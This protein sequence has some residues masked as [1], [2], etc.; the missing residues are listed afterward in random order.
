MSEASARDSA[1][2]EV[3]SRGATS[4]ASTRDADSVRYIVLRKLASGMR[5]ALMG[6]L[7]T[8]EFFAEFAARLLDQSDQSK[9]RECIEKIAPATQAAVKTCHS[10]IEWLRPDETSTLS[11]GDA[12]KQCLKLA[13]DDWNLRGI[14]ATTNVPEQ[15]AGVQL[16]KA[17][18]RDV[19]V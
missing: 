18:A 14:A 5:H 3:P 7:Q 8:V 16:S 11:V 13:A 1:T 19:I 15:V 10:I 17:A 12:L 4:D 2:S 9:L 6:E